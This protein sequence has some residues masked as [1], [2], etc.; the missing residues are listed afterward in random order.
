MKFD[1]SRIS[2]STLIQSQFTATSIDTIILDFLRLI[3]KPFDPGI[4]RV[5]ANLEHLDVAA[6]DSIPDYDHLLNCDYGDTYL[7]W[8]LLL[9]QETLAWPDHH[10]LIHYSETG[11]L[12]TQ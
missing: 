8:L 10:F 3:L 1:T 7:S 4:L 6:F 5:I 12:A 11:L 2:T 9:D